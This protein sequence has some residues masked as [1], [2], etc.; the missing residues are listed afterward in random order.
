MLHKNGGKTTKRKTQ[1]QIDQIRKDIQMRDE[2]WEEII[3]KKKKT[4]S[5]RVEV[6]KDFSVIVS[7]ETIWP[8][9]KKDLMTKYKKKKL[10]NFVNKI[11]LE[12]V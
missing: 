10:V 3:K 9:I 12:N 2:N 7:L 5:G 1:N 6:T 4:E 8:P 11:Q